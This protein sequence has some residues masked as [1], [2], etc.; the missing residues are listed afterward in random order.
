M[1]NSCFSHNEKKSLFLDTESPY[2]AVFASNR[3]VRVRPDGKPIEC[4]DYTRDLFVLE[5]ASVSETSMAVKTRRVQ[6]NFP[7]TVERSTYNYYDPFSPL[8]VIPYVGQDGAIS[9]SCPLGME[10]ELCQEGNSFV[11]MGEP[12]EDQDAK[13]LCWILETAIVVL[14]RLVL[15]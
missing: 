13:V 1:A 7:V 10:Y 15:F 14:K 12:F 8:S 11:V 3:K 5:R 4:L 2:Q 9:Y 6:V